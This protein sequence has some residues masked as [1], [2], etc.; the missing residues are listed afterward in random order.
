MAVGTQPNELTPGER[1]GRRPLP[2]VLVGYW[3]LAAALFGAALLWIF[4]RGYLLHQPYPF[5]TFLFDPKLRYSD[6]TDYWERFQHFRQSAFYASAGFPHADTPYVYPPFMSVV[7]WLCWIAPVKSLHLFWAV[8]VAAAAALAAVFVRCLIRRQ[9]RAWVAVLFTLTVVGTSYP[10]WVVWD[11]ANME[12]FVWIAVSAGLIAYVRRRWWWAASLF[13]VATA[14]KYFPLVFFALLISRRK[15]RETIYGM[16]ATASLTIGS[17]SLMGPSIA[18]AWAHSRYSLRVLK[19]FWILADRAGEIGFQHSL[20]SVLRQACALTNASVHTL[21]HAYSSYLYL[22]AIGG[23]ALYWLRIRKLPVLNQVLA[24]AICSVLLPPWSADYTLVHLYVP[25]ALLALWIVDHA[26]ENKRALWILLPFAVVFT[27]QP[28][29]LLTTAALNRG[30]SGQVKAIALVLIL[31]AC[32]R[33][34][35][36]D[37]S[38]DADGEPAR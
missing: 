13:A 37:A 32:L 18:E 19:H 14:L 5:N 26:N 20:F 31:I 29:F 27:P 25:W 8:V 4:V 34:R 36:G 22:V 12:V 7:F 10:M 2:G 38:L 6:L 11:R 17:L 15:W 24:L 16:A 28:Y 30:Y 21:Q 35:F 1:L 33:I 23:L 3:W 9:I